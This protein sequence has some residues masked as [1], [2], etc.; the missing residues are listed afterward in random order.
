MF[1]KSSFQ[2]SAENKR[3]IMP[4]EGFYEHHHFKNNAYPFFI[5]HKEG[6]PFYLQ[7]YG[8]TGRIL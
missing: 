2:A 4:A 7:D 6:K 1:E 3:C 5:R 8:M